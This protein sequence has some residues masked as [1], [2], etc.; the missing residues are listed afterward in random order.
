[1][2]AHYKASIDNATEP[3][4]QAV[5]TGAVH[6]LATKDRLALGRGPVFTL[7]LG[8]ATII[9]G[10]PKRAA[11][12]LSTV[13]NEALVK[14]PRSSIIKLDSAQMNERSVR[15]LIDFINGN[16][17]TNKPFPLRV[18]ETLR[19]LVNL[20][21]H[22]C[23]LGMDGNAG[24]LRAEILERL[25]KKFNVSYAALHEL[26]RLPIT[27]TCWRAAVRKVEGLVHIGAIKIDQDWQSWIGTH[28]HFLAAM[29][30]WKTERE[31]AAA[32]NRQRRQEAKETQ[33][34]IDWENAFPPLV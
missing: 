24:N 33:R 2:S 6:R 22:A 1:M 8:D 11:M 28:P 13:L 27:N 34:A 10:V 4:T 19:E 29:T 7:N 21:R 12:A 26:S 25:N 3:A 32:E 15:I 30:A 5:I 18:P 31:A 14:Y 16:S 23:I 17:K 20:Y 9:E